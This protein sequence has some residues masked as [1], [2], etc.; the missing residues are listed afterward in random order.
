MTSGGALSTM[1]Q[2]G[3]DLYTQALAQ[4]LSASNGLP[5]N[6]L[7]PANGSQ[8]PPVLLHFSDSSNAANS[9][10][11]SGSSIT[12]NVPAE[13]YTHLQIY[14]TSTGGTSGIT[15]TL[16]YSDNSSVPTPTTIP[17]WDL[18]SQSLAS[19]VFVLAGNLGRILNGSI[20]NTGGYFYT[21]YGV[22]VAV[23]PA[24]TLASVTVAGTSGPGF[25]WF[26]GA[27]AWF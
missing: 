17:D 6:G 1:D 9:V 8:N 15:I 4:Q 5:N 13:S 25:L 11:V 22:N 12:I 24:K 19:P 18:G 27:T 14:C 2:G 16:N 7:F 3:D 10:Y 20:S 26:Y 23:D 21:L